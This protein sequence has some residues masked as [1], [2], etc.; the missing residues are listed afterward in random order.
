MIVS[1]IVLNRPLGQSARN[2][3]DLYAACIAG[4][5]LRQDYLAAISDAGF[6][7]VKVVSDHTYMVSNA[8]NDPVT[9]VI[10]EILAGVAA[11]ITVLA[12]K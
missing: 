10:G 2:D 11:S 7:E 1:D 5:M 3:A 8:S 4:A 9:G 6:T 12:V